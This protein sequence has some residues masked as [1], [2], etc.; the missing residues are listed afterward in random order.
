MEAF[1]VAY[2]VLAL[3]LAGVCVAGLYGA[4]LTLRT[5][6]QTGKKVITLDF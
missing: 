5:G 4:F 1:V 6:R 3:Y 2:I